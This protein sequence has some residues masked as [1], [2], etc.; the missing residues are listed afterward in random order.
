MAPQVEYLGPLLSMALY[1]TVLRTTVYGAGTRPIPFELPAFT[2]EGALPAHQV[3]SLALVLWTAIFA[4]RELETIFV[5]RFSR[6]TMPLFNIFK[7]S[8]YYWF[9]GAFCSYFV[10]HPSVR[11]RVAGA[12]RDRP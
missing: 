8:G 6:A 10:A 11:R 4:K 9:F 1:W 2:L 7:N 3:Q 12:T 5:H